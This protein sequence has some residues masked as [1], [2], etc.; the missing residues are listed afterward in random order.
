M[1]ASSERRRVSPAKVSGSFGTMRSSLTTEPVV[2][3]INPSTGLICAGGL[4]SLVPP[5][6][7]SMPTAVLTWSGTTMM[8]QC[9]QNGRSTSACWRHCCEVSSST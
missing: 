6:I 4:L 1:I 9:F 8:S 5:A 2:F 3:A 7:I